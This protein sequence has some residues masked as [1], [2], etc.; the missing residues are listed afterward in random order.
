M[1]T[2]LLIV[3]VLVYLSLALV[4]GMHPV[5]HPI[6][7]YE[8]KRRSSGN[9][10]AKWQ[11]RR[12]ILL[13]DVYG[14]LA[15]KSAVLLVAF[16]A[17]S[18]ATFGWALGISIALLGTVLYPTIAHWAF[19]HKWSTRI[20]VQYEAA[21][22]DAIESMRP[23]FNVV[24]AVTI[25]HVEPYHRFDSREELQHLI[26]QA[27]DVLSENEKLLINNGLSFKDKTVASVM[28]PK[29]AIKYVKKTEFLGPLV[30][31]EIHELGHSRLPVID[32][33]IDH[34][35]GTL[36]LNDLLSLDQ[37]RS[38]TAEKAME[39]KTYYIGQD[40]TLEHALAAFIETRH[41]LFIVLNEY[42]ETVGLLTLEDVIASLVGRKIEDENDNH[43]DAHAVAQ[44]N[45]ARNNAAAGH[46]DI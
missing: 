7:K 23:V 6:S 26:Q 10:A 39:A 29:S 34:V 16:V 15:A 46:V 19:V 25:P 14:A 8:L 44:K 20:Y 21:Y 38:T 27:G 43:E 37:K 42:R 33:D 35:V 9:K 13:P 41:H 5:P 22:L 45:V 11:H 24:R 31:S 3:T 30:L 36:H 17:L 1:F 4:A 40:D 12:E 2:F 18:I 32:E 28:T